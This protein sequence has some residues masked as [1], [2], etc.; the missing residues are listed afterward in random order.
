VPGLFAAG[1]CA[2]GMHGANRLGGNSLS[3]LLVFGH[4]AG[5][6]ATDYVRA[7]P[8]RPAVDMRQVEAAV[9]QATEPLNRPEGINPYVVTEHL[10]KIMDRY[11]NIV[12]ERQE[13][14]TALVELG[15]IRREIERVKAPGASQY[16][17]GWHEAIALRSLLI[18]AEAVTRAGLMREESRG[19]HTR[20]DF[21]GER[22]EWGQYNVVVR[23]GAD[24]RME[25]RKEK[26][27]DPP[28]ELA[29]V[30]YATL[31]DLEGEGAAPEKGA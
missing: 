9:T 24:G 7:Q 27:L 16:N 1:E 8:R 6:G 19:A 25:V 26:R 28:V 23:R 31:A 29:A 20:T 4:L 10:Q 11:V 22:D 13:L 12:R 5:V 18:T 15:E 30:A 17:P 14:E 21:P 3:D 2:G